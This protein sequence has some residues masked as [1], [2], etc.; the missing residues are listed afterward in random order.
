VAF[1]DLR[2]VLAQA[3]LSTASSRPAGNQGRSEEAA[4]RPAKLV[5]HPAVRAIDVG[6]PELCPEP[7]AFLDGVQH[8][9]VVAYV[10]TSPLV[11]G[12]A[13]AA[14][15]ER[16]GRRLV[17]VVET[18]RRMVVGRMTALEQIPAS[19]ANYEPIV[20]D[21][22]EEEHPARELDRAAGKIDD[23]RSALERQ[24]G[25][26]FRGDSNA[27]LVVD[28]SLAECRD[29][30]DDPRMLGVS[31]SHAT[32]P[33]RGDD[34]RAYLRMAQGHRSSIFEPASRQF[35]PVYAWGLRL[36]DWNARDLLFGL[37]RVEA[38]RRAETL[39]SADRWSRWILA[40]RAPVSA[41]DVRWDRLLYGIR[42]VEDYLHARLPS[43]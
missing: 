37:V 34:L 42:N 4:I 19:L 7:L 26:A 35:A 39:A 27:W 9:Q 5:E 31:K 23:V 1:D 16:R 43:L 24:L 10:G 30:A 38:S 28:G 15:R 25:R 20:I 40:E 11:A 13:A 3:G 12:V 22:D 2:R 33:F 17:T 21:D 8:H 18:R 41:P 6:S 32:L 36:W 29:F 14:V